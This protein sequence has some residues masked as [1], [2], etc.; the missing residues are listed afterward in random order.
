MTSLRVFQPEVPIPVG[1]GST[2]P[3][4]FT[5]LELTHHC[6]L[7]CQQCY[8]N[9]SPQMP[10]GS[11]TTRRWLELLDEILVAGGG[12]VQLTG[13]EATTH[14]D[15]WTILEHGT[16]LQLRMEVF[17]NATSF[18]ERGLDRIAELG[19]AIATSLHS[20]LPEVHDEVT[21]TPGSWAPVVAAI[22]GLV[23]RGV[24]VRVATVLM[25]GN[26]THAPEVERLIRSLGVLTPYKADPVRPTGRG[27]RAEAPAELT[28]CGGCDDSAF[29]V[30]HTTPDGPAPSTCWD[31][32]IAVTPDG[33]VYPC[34]FSR[35][36]PVGDVKSTPL[37][38]VLAEGPLAAFWGL[39]VE[40]VEECRECDRKGV[41]F[42]CRALPL[43]ALGDV[44]AKNPRCDYVPPAQRARRERP[45]RLAV[46]SGLVRAWC[47]GELLV[48]D[49]ATAQLHRLNPSAAALFE[50]VQAT[51]DA[52]EA[53]R[54]TVRTFE[55]SPPDVE[56]V[57]HEALTEMW[58]ARLL[59]DENGSDLFGEAVDT[60]A[61]LA[62]PTR[63]A[64]P[65][66]AEVRGHVEVGNGC[67]R[68][69]ASDDAWRVLEPWF[70][71]FLGDRTG[72]ER[73]ALSVVSRRSSSAHRALHHV[74]VDAKQFG[75]VRTPGAV[76]SMVE[77]ALCV[78]ASRGSG[79]LRFHAG[80]FVH[81]GGGVVLLPGH[82]GTGKSL[83]TLH[84]VAA[85]GGYLTDE[86]ATLDPRSREISGLAK[87]VTV[88]GP[89]HLHVPE[90]LRE[91]GLPV[92]PE[93]EDEDE[94]ESLWI[95]LPAT[96][97]DTLRAIVLPDRSGE[98]TGL[99]PISPAEAVEALLA[100]VFNL[101]EFG[102]ADAL[103][104]VCALA[105]DTPCYRLDTRDLGAAAALLASIDLAR[106][107]G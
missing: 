87:P 9:S 52:E 33:T 44:M 57:L 60:A 38:K 65:P 68:I 11:M 100:E 71:G 28:S 74:M 22:E 64:P 37:P 59:V 26:A 105:E 30:L 49:G 96:G 93:Y 77:Q 80:A 62:P 1:G 27:R 91:R 29:E 21:R 46:R 34:I 92:D 51:G 25:A 99:V 75:A 86:I 4:D 90:A 83:L 2:R 102:P 53:V 43:M 39:T 84:C 85:G 81:P 82:S 78:L 88:K 67:V 48:L 17:T 89:G 63:L 5:W 47:A 14:P 8:T 36:A 55:S 79:R 56:G 73:G 7:R 18:D 69:E 12:T 35:V 24:E 106:A 94:D 32:K 61:P 20:H 58:E 54:D 23:Q 19:T 40:D 41:C 72:E 31:G 70:D 98:T 97:P 42:D 15:F 45:A 101:G 76:R 50:A 16:S 66:L 103:A 95:P 10:H 107:A 3:L 13:G 104:S 6:N